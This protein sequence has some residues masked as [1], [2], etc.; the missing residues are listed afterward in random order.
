M[1]KLRQKISTPTGGNR[2]YRGEMVQKMRGK[3]AAGEKPE[4][5][6]AARTVKKTKENSDGKEADG[7]SK[8]STGKARGQLLRLIK[9][10]P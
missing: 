10:A 7:H 9:A 8:T 2:P 3:T 1:S 5:V 4:G 6:P